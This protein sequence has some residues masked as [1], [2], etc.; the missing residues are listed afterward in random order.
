[1]KKTLF[2]FAFVLLL[3]GPSVVRAESTTL[4]TRWTFAKEWISYN[5]FTLKAESKIQLINGLS[6]QRTAEIKLA[7]EQNS[8]D[9]VK[10][11]TFRLENMIQKQNRIV[12]KK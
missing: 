7:A 8:A 9:V 6:N 12:E 4:P 10:N 3:V 2:I 1:M 5:V 11:L